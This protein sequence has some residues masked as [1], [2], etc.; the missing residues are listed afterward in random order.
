MSTPADSVAVLGT[1][2]APAEWTAIETAQCVLGGTPVTLVR[3]VHAPWEL[4]ITRIDDEGVFPGVRLT[5]AALPGTDLWVTDVHQ[6]IDLCAGRGTDAEDHSELRILVPWDGDV[7][8]VD[9]VV[10]G[11]DGM[12]PQVTVHDMPGGYPVIIATRHGAEPAPVP[13]VE[14]STQTDADG[15]PLRFHRTG[16]LIPEVELAPDGEGGHAISVKWPDR[17][18]DVIEVPA[19]DHAAG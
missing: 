4:R 14:E 1:G 16:S 7:T 17:E 10:E 5:G 6:G 9:A 13:Q 3:A 8:L 11:V 12:M 2:R 18:R 15:K 19:P